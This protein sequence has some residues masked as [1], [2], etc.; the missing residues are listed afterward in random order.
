MSKDKHKK[1]DRAYAF[2]RSLRTRMD[3]GRFAL[4][5]NPYGPWGKGIAKATVSGK[6]PAIVRYCVRKGMATLRRGNI[7]IG[8]RRHNVLD[9]E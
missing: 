4:G 7:G 6:I 8:S 3:T 9:A 1:R 2:I 5:V